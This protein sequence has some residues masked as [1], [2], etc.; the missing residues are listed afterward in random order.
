[1]YYTLYEIRPEH[2]ANPVH[3]SINHAHVRE[4]V[5][6]LY[7]ELQEDPLLEPHY[8]RELGN[9]WQD[10]LERAIDFWQCALCKTP[11]YQGRPVPRLLAQRDHI[12]ESEVDRWQELFAKAAQQSVPAEAVMPVMNVANLLSDSIRQAMKAA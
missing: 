7:Q 1:M 10:D 8:T 11:S 2:E 6:Q 12:S 3:P 4:L 9:D 5:N